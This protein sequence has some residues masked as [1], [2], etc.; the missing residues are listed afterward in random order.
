MRYAASIVATAVAMAA[1]AHAGIANADDKWWPAKYYNLDS[2]SA[3][4]AEYTPLE[5]GVEALEH[6]RAVSAYEGHLLGGRRL[7]RRRGSQTDGREHDALSGGRLREP[8]EAACRSSTTA[9]PAI[10]TR[11]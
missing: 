2:G 3:K 10:S 5:K 8:A 9:C 1:L 4:V 6:L 7:R 11:S